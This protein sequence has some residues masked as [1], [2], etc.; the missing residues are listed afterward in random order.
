MEKYSKTSSKMY[1]HS[2]Q[3]KRQQKVLQKV[4]NNYIAL[5]VDKAICVYQVSGISLLIA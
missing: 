4:N 3:Q 1:R 2:V 5:F